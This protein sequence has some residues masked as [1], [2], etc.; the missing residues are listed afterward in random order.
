VGAE[1]SL[2][3]A[4][5][6]FNRLVGYKQPPTMNLPKTTALLL[7]LSV[8]VMLPAQK[9]G[10]LFEPAQVKQAMARGTRLP[11]G[12]PGKNYFQNRAVYDLSATFEP[13]TRML[14]GAGT[15]T[16]ENNSPDSLNQLIF[17]LFQNI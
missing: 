13:D 17:N 4:F 8:T 11:T 1:N 10:T 5:R 7:A 16:Y 12:K 9:T 15:I 6:F 14:S 2:I 3:A